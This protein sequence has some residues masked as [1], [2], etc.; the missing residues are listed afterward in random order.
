MNLEWKSI[1][2]I[3]KGQHKHDDGASCSNRKI[4]RP[5]IEKLVVE[6]LLDQ[7][8]QP[9]W[10]TTILTTLKARRDDRQASA[11]RR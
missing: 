4:P 9:E 7:L 3:K 8:L 5:V 10:V 2:S 1:Q 6:A 11:D